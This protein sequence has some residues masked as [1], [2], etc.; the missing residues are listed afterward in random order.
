VIS[1]LE[2]R[3]HSSSFCPGLGLETWSPRSR[4]WSRDL[5]KGLDNN[6]GRNLR[7]GVTWQNLEALT[8]ARIRQSSAFYPEF[9]QHF[10][11]I[12]SFD[13]F[14]VQSEY[15]LAISTANYWYMVTQ[16]STCLRLSDN[17]VGAITWWRRLPEK[18]CRNPIGTDTDRSSTH[19]FQPWASI[20]AHGWTIGMRMAW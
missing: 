11:L 19:D 17:T 5:R 9:L 8:T 13:C 12:S 10:L 18:F 15:L 1:R 14:I 20:E 3:V 4:S 16:P 6:I 2:T 7:I